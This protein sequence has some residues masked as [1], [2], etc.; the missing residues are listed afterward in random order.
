MGANASQLLERL[1]RNVEPRKLRKHAQLLLFYYIV[2][3]L[4]SKLH[5]QRL[6]SIQSYAG[7]FSPTFLRFSSN[8]L[9]W[10]SYWGVATTILS[11]TNGVSANTIVRKLFGVGGIAFGF[12]AQQTIS[13]LISGVM[14]LLSHPFKIGDHIEAAGVS[15]WVLEVGL[16]HTYVNTDEHVRVMLPNSKVLNTNIIN[17]SMLVAQVVTKTVTL[18]DERDLK[19]TRKKLQ[20]AGAEVDARVQER[21]KAVYPALALEEKYGRNERSTKWRSAGVEGAGRPLTALK[22]SWISLVD[23]SPDKKTSE[24]KLYVWAATEDVRLVRDW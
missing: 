2:Y 15:G 7:L 10:A 3:R 11:I 5:R 19:E 23:V 9:Q 8:T 22:P 6:S 1:A 13:N 20:E 24:W 4:G 12:A 14:I 16:M 18:S 21:L 17:N